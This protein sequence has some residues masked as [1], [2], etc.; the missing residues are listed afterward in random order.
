MAGGIA[1]AKY[2][3]DDA[4]GG[5]AGN[6]DGAQAAFTRGGDYGGNGIVTGYGLFFFIADY[7]TSTAVA[8]VFILLLPKINCSRNENSEKEVQ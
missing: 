2:F 7:L 4:S 3:F 8:S 6:T 1:G 5:R